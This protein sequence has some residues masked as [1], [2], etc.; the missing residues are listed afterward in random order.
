MNI[1]IYNMIDII[2][3]IIDYDNDMMITIHLNT[4]KFSYTC[5]N[6]NNNIIAHII[7]STIHYTLTSLYV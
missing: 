1:L 3:N 5:N 6:D 7:Y 4:Y 2:I